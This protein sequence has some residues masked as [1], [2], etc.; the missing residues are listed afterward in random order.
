MSIFDEKHITFRL[1]QMPPD[2]RESYLEIWK[3]IN[4]LKPCR[5]MISFHTVSPAPRISVE[6]IDCLELK[7]HH[8]AKG[9]WPCLIKLPEHILEA[10]AVF[11][12]EIYE[13]KNPV[14]LKLNMEYGAR[15]LS[16][17]EPHI[18]V[19]DSTFLRYNPVLSLEEILALEKS[20]K[21]GSC[22]LSDSVSGIDLHAKS[23]TMW[24]TSLFPYGPGFTGLN[25]F[26][27]PYVMFSNKQV[28]DL[29]A[30]SLEAAVEEEIKNGFTGIRIDK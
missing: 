8:I 21:L 11:L 4:A 5:D 17:G 16:W 6:L 15:V 25:G 13:G 9:N 10:E 22:L 14:L 1:L 2:H 18:W 20:D 24:S 30:E 27:L 28:A 19:R 26:N 3:R 7:T 23:I 29:Y 12:I